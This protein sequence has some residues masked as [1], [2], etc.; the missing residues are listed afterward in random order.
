[1]RGGYKSYVSELRLAERDIR[2]CERCGSKFPA[3]RLSLSKTC[4]RCKQRVD[5]PSIQGA[6]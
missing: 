1:M 4:P 3:K 6:R 5:A 2:V